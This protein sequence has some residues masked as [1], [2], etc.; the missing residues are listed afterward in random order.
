[1]F[2]FFLFAMDC[3]LERI[4][5]DNVI[6]ILPFTNFSEGQKDGIQFRK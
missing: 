6:F 3:R 1:M 5:K 2:K 4:R